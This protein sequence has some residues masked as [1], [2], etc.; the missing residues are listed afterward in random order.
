MTK[1]TVL[2]HNL[3]I[4]YSKFAIRYLPVIILYTILS[5]IGLSVDIV[6]PFKMGSIMDAAIGTNEC[7]VVSLLVQ[8]FLMVLILAIISYIKNIIALRIS[9][10]MSQQIK[11]NIMV[12][13]MALPMKD[14]DLQNSG[15]IMSKWGDVERITSFFMSISN[16]IFMNLLLFTFTAIILY[17]ISPLLAFFQYVNIPILFIIFRKFGKI[18]KRKEKDTI[19]KRDTLYTFLVEM[20]QGIREIKPLG[21]TAN[22]LDRLFY[23]HKDYVK[24]EYE[25]GK[26]SI[27]LGSSSTLF[28]G[29]TQLIFL[30]IACIEIINGKLTL[31]MYYAFNAYAN[32]FSSTLSIFANFGIELQIV[33]VA[34]ERIVEYCKKDKYESIGTEKIWIEEIQSI[35]V[36]NISFGYNCDT[37]VLRGV[38]AKF[39]KNL[40]YVIVGSNGCGKSTLLNLIM[41]IYRPSKGE[42]L[43]NDIDISLIKEECLLSKIVYIRQKPFFFNMSITDNMKLVDKDIS[44]DKIRKVCDVVGLHTFIEQLPQ[45]Y[46]TALGEAGSHFSGGQIHRLALARGLLIDADVYILDEVTA[47]LDGESEKKIM[48]ILIKMAIDGKLVIMVSHKLSTITRTNNIMVMEEGKII[49]RGTHEKLIK[50][51]DRYKKLYGEKNA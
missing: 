19:Q 1:N 2:I 49:A 50:E 21:G 25:K 9:T 31:G 20:L 4:I 51:C 14:I 34:A 43:I 23:I 18:I 5:A 39:D 40:L 11:N 44:I 48:D 8:A 12:K 42:I 38:S 33:S 15:Q 35:K 17:R 30:L 41:S 13:V 36:N 10:Q 24:K 7:E 29:I 3:K 46:G 16:N 27:T 32:R 6:L 47:D 26:I 37:E 28:S 22:V 45:G